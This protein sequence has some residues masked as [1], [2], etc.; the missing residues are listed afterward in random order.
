VAALLGRRKLVLKV[1]TGSTSLDQ[2]THQLVRIQVAAKTSLS[3]S[4]Q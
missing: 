2:G 1:N 4:L 3:I